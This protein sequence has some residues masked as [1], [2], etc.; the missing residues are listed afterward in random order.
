MRCMANTML[1]YGTTALPE[2]KQKLACPGSEQLAVQ[3]L[4]ATA[5]QHV[6][7]YRFAAAVQPTLLKQLDHV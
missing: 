2:P 6:M 5:I 7:Q 1:A 3:F 4:C